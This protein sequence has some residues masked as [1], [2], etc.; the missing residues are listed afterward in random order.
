M[1]EATIK[2][3]I[4][5]R[6]ETQVDLALETYFRKLLLGEEVRQTDEADYERL[7]AWRRAKLVDLTPV[8]KTH[9]SRDLLQKTG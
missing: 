7:L 6:T 3:I 9:R 1:S 5:E 8:K 2:P 4:G